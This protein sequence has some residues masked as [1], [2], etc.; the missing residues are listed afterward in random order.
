MQLKLTS[1]SC[2]HCVDYC[3][4]G[5]FSSALG[6]TFMLA[7]ALGVVPPFT[8]GGSSARWVWRGVY[9]IW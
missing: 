4:S 6:F 8:G 2:L 9:A 5:R 3:Q 1:V 7:H